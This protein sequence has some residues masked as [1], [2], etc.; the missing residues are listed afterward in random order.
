MSDSLN[1]FLL[2]SIPSTLVPLLIFLYLSYRNRQRIDQLKQRGDEYESQRAELYLQREAQITRQ[3]VTIAEKNAD[4]LPDSLDHLR[5][6]WLEAE[7]IGLVDQGRHRSNLDALKRGALPLLQLLKRPVKTA[8]TTTS[9]SAAAQLRKARN[10][11]ALQMDSIAQIRQAVSSSSHNESAEHSPAQKK[12]TSTLGDVE[13]NTQTLMTTIARLETELH[14]LQHK[15]DSTEAKLREACRTDQQHAPHDL[16]I[17]ST[18]NKNESK[19][20]ATREL[21]QETTQAYQQSVAEINRMREINRKQ[22][23][24]IMQLET[25]ISLLRQD[26]TQYETSFA[27]LGQLKLQL[28]DY[29]TCTVILETEGDTLRDKITQ[30]TKLIEHEEPEDSANPAPTPVTTRHL[31]TDTATDLATL[32]LAI[33]KMNTAENVIGC[34]IEW[35][36]QK[37]LSAVILVRGRREQLWLSSEGSIDSHSK[38]LLQS[39][40]AKPDSPVVELSEGLL[41]AYPLC[42][43]LIYQSA[44]LTT[45]TEELLHVFPAIDRWL[46]MIEAEK[47]TQQENMSHADIHSEL[48]KLLGQYNY[49]ITEH[50]R[51]T[52]KFHGE[53][54]E[55][56]TGPGLSDSQREYA[57]GMLEDF[58]SQQDIIGKA[59]KLVYSGLKT[60]IQNI[61]ADE[62]T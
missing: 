5:L 9:D 8:D 58:Q 47:F 30:L 4:T 15:F 60:V 22:R 37:K 28:R 3:R 25:E 32:V 49:V 14:S 59:S 44:N 19:L 55:F 26:S 38:Q 57:A 40:S 45:Y 50:H 24:L 16:L 42:H 12:V 41:F 54:Q 29:E 17:I 18:P 52:Q 13:Q 2:L 62:S 56:L 53:L 39:I 35:L 48:N 10:A 34:V 11:L 20:D 7:L 6:I 33:L 51:A 23:G 1:F 36:A 21:L 27:I 46:A 61:D 43:V 31:A